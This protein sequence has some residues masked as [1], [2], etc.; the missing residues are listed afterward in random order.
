M[1]ITVRIW[2]SA[3]F[4]RTQISLRNEVM[5]I[6]E[7][8]LIMMNR[9]EISQDGCSFWNEMSIVVIISDAGMGSAAHH[10]NWP[11]SECFF[12]DSRAIGE[13]WRVTPS[14]RT[15]TADYAIELFLCLRGY[16]RKTGHC[17]DKARQGRGRSIA[18]RAK[19]RTSRICNLPFGKSF[20]VLFSL[21]PQGLRKTCRCISRFHSIPNIKRELRKQL[22][23]L[24]SPTLDF[25]LPGG[26]TIRDEL[27]YR[28][29]LRPKCTRSKV[30][31][32]LG[33]F[34]NLWADRTGI[35]TH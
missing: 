7:I 12:D 17:E 25:P 34:F 29:R 16:S 6:F 15:I 33:L 35:L 30:K 21:L 31:A 10:G 2:Q 18:S 22:G 4:T 27:E 14:R 19:Q 9:P 20:W 3:I 24:F 32:Q 13:I 11:P 23:G 28:E 26:K 5:G 8:F 1:S